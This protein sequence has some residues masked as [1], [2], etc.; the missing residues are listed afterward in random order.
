MA[1]NGGSIG[2][3]LVTTEISSCL[4]VEI[5]AAGIKAD[6]EEQPAC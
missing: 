5:M 1:G 4:V 3:E 6:C 2:S